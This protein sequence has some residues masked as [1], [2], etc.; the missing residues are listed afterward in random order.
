MVL[1]L[2]SFWLRHPVPGKAASP[3]HA[4]H[5]WFGELCW[6]LAAFR[7][8]CRSWS[9]AQRRWSRLALQACSWWT[10]RGRVGDACLCVICLLKAVPGCMEFIMIVAVSHNILRIACYPLV[11]RRN[12]RKQ[13]FCPGMM[14][15]DSLKGKG[16]AFETLGLSKAKEGMSTF[17][18]FSVLLLVLRFWVLG[19]RMQFY[20]PALSQSHWCATNCGSVQTCSEECQT[21]RNMC[22]DS[23]LLSIHGT[24]LFTDV[25]TAWTGAYYIEGGQYFFFFL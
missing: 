24:G 15:V 17:P 8:Y 19:N 10:R 14:E 23:T 4:E 9:P 13:E 6:A 1:F 16:L 18:L 3:L 21:P 12:P 5:R 7:L 22:K 11:R 25:P 20:L 2:T